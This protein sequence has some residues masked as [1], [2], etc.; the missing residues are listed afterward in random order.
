MVKVIKGEVKFNGVFHGK[1]AVITG[2]SE[3]D[4][5]RLVEK[6]VAE[7][8]PEMAQEPRTEPEKETEIEEDVEEEKQEEQAETEEQEEAVAEPAD[9]EIKFDLN[10]CIVTEGTPKPAPQKQAKSAKKSGKK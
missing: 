3:Q 10:D 9:T 6:G 4:E 8:V 2:L 7:Y 1:G 5:A